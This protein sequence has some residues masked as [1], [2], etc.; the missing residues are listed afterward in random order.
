MLS[1]TTD[2]SALDEEHA[3]ETLAICI[4]AGTWCDGSRG[5]KFYE[6]SYFP[7]W[8]SRGAAGHCSEGANSLCIARF[9]LEREGVPCCSCRGTGVV[10]G[11][12]QCA[13]LYS[14]GVGGTQ[15]I[16]NVNGHFQLVRCPA[17]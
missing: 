15:G 8:W 1:G 3:R 5:R 6:A 13:R 4:L 11:R 16:G 17:P 12:L 2:C 9:E 7:S 14:F 10:T